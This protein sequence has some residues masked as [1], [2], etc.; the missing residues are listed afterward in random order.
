MLSLVSARGVLRGTVRGEDGA[1]I[2]GVK[3]VGCGSAVVTPLDG[4]WSY[5][6][7]VGP[8][9][10]FFF[11]GEGCSARRQIVVP[12]RRDL[13]VDL[14]GLCVAGTLHPFSEAEELEKMQKVVARSREVEAQLCEKHF[15]LCWPDFLF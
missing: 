15:W 14:E 10:L 1:P 9:E 12:P 6:A 4:R 7:N 5:D 8:C 2:G 13:E 3:V 11:A